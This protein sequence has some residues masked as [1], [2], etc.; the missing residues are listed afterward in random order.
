MSR[1]E[2]AASVDKLQAF[3]E[4]QPDVEYFKVYL[5]EVRAVRAFSKMSCW[6]C[7]LVFRW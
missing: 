5:E 1:S 3:A 2:N 7:S 6:I 4:E